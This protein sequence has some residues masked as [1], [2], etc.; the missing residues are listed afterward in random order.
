MR[1]IPYYSSVRCSRGF[2]LRTEFTETW[3]LDQRQ[4]HLQA[5][6][7][8]FESPLH[9]HQLYAFQLDTVEGCRA[10]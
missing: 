3:K 2:F 10:I 7:R 5:G 6:G 8:G 4:V 1:M 9:V